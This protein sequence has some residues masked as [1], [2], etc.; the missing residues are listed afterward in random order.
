MNSLIRP[1]MDKQKLNIG[2]SIELMNNTTKEVNLGTFKKFMGNVKEAGKYLGQA[3]R[4]ERKIDTIWE[5]QTYTLKYENCS[6]DIEML[7][8]ANNHS[9]IVKGFKFQ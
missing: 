7:A 2:L 8:S 1:D 3:L 9:Q 5:N 4:R 6:L